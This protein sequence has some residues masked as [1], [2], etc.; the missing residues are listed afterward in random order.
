MALNN[1]SKV[2]GNAI[3]SMLLGTA[4]GGQSG[5][6]ID[7]A[8]SLYSFGLYFQDRWHATRKLTVSMGLRYEN[9]RP[10]TERHDRLMYFNE[11]VLNPL[12]NVISPAYG[13][14]LNQVFRLSVN[15]PFPIRGQLA[16]P[17]RLARHAGQ[18]RASPRYCLSDYA[19]SGR[20]YGRRH[21]LSASIGDDQLRQPGAILWVQFRRRTTTH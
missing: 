20:A 12:G 21:L 11:N 18:F 13:E 14:T 4:S 17:L 15:R 3:A 1:T 5:I 2:S 9:Q 16:K 10:A 8:M 6:N 19:T 7:P